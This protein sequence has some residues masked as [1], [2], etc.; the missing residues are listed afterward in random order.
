MKKLIYSLLISLSIFFPSIL[1]AQWQLMD[2]P[3]GGC[4]RSILCTDS[5]YYAATSGGVLVSSDHGGTWEFRNNGLTSC[6][7]KSL[8]ECNDTIF[9]S[10][11]ENVFRTTDGGLH[12]EADPYLHNH[13][14][15]HVDVHNG[16][17]YA[18]SYIQGV[19]QSTQGTQG[20]YKSDAF[21]V[22]VRYPYFIAHN[23]STIFIATYLRGIYRSYDNGT[24]W[25][26]CNNGLGSTDIMA[27]YCHDDRVFAAILGNGVFISD[28]DGDSWTRCTLNSQVKGFAHDDQALYAV[29][30]DEGVYASF[31]NGDSWIPWST[32][33]AADAPLC[34]A[35][36]GEYIFVGDSQGRVY[37]G[38]SDGSGWSCVSNQPFYASVGNIGIS[39]N[40]V[41]AAS[42]GSNLYY[43]D[44]GHSW[45]QKGVGTVEI[46]GMMVEDN[47]VFIGTDMLGSFLSTNGGNSFSNAGAGLPENHWLQRMVRCGDRIAVGSKDRMF[48]SF[49][50]GQTWYVPTCLPLEIDVVDID[51]D[52][53]NMYHVSYDGVARYSAELGSNWQ[54]F[55][56]PFQNVNY[57][58]LR[59]HNGAIYL[60]TRGHGLHVTNDMGTNWS[61]IQALPSDATI[62]RITVS[63]TIIA[64]GCEDGSIFLK[65]DHC[66]EW[67]QMENIPVEGPILDICINGN[68][69]YAS[70]MAGGVWYSELPTAPDG[71]S[72]DS[73]P[74][75]SIAPN[76][77]ADVINLTIDESLQN[78]EVYLYDIQGRKCI[79]TPVERGTC[80]LSTQEIPSGIYFVKLV[81]GDTI[82]IQKVVVQH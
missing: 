62:R 82:A 77:T 55:N 36:D 26:S 68:R 18:A 81:G 41:L 40:R 25:E 7:T 38:K 16:Q 8:A 20:E 49:G 61:N 29:S 39:G 65:Y 46:R 80:Q 72:E 64:V 44:N 58:A 42:H 10:T 19:Y 59:C 33:L 43:T 47:V 71:I 9:L 60:G 75:L 22:D 1:N 73:E 34:I 15:K 14:I 31:D 24:T 3:M 28:N 52:G 45:I 63:D 57:T 76:P 13:Y 66:G 23:E 56:S 11:D 35:A 5:L 6:D 12:W 74:V 67:Q 54:V 27:V 21:P 53:A 78:A 79:T 17:L 2:G 69:I 48:V 30:F 50:I 37:R 51:W 32:G 70:P 4:V